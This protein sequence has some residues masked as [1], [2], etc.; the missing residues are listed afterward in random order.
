MVLFNLL[1]INIFNMLVIYEVVE[2]VFI[3]KFN[4]W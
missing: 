3:L 1:N 2:V 4:V